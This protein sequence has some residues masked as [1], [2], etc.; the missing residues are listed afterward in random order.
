MFKKLGYHQINMLHFICEYGVNH[1]YSIARDRVSRRVANSLEKRGILR[2][3]RDFE[4]WVVSIP[5]ELFETVKES[6]G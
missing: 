4:C 1:R 6:F 3:N 5:S 2:V